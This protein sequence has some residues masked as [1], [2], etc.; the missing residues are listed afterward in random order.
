MTD[1]VNTIYKL[2]DQIFVKEQIFEQ[3]IKIY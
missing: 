3:K 2:E 1:K